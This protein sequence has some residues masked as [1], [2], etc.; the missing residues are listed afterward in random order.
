MSKNKKKAAPS[1]GQSG[2]ELEL[3]VQDLNPRELRCVMFLDQSG[4]FGDASGKRQDFTIEE[5]A[6]G[7]FKSKSKAQGNSWVRNCLRRLVRAKLVDK[8]DRGVYR[9]A[10]KTRNALAKLR[11]EQAAKKTA[12]KEAAEKKAA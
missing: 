8:Q 7:A 10:T 2:P 5:M 3:S 4:P 6:A 11:N 1:S 12:K 9:V